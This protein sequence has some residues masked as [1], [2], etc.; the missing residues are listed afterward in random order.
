MAAIGDSKPIVRATDMEQEEL[1]KVIE[2]VD[3]ALKEPIKE[4]KQ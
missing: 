1:S 2:L 4:M 3:L